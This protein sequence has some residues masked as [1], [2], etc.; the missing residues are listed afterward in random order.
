MGFLLAAAGDLQKKMN[1]GPSDIYWP[2]FLLEIHA[3]DGGL[4]A[5]VHDHDPERTSIREALEQKGFQV[6]VGATADSGFQYLRNHPPSGAILGHTSTLDALSLCR[7]IRAEPGLRKLPVLLMTSGGEPG[8]LRALEAGADEVV[9]RPVKTRELLARL[10]TL[11]RRSGPRLLRED[12]HQAGDLLVDEGRA[13]ATFR[14]KTSDMS[15]MEMKILR[16]LA[17]HPDRVIQRE[18][19]LKVLGKAIVGEGRCIDAHMVYIRRKLGEDLVET[20]P[21]RGYRLKNQGRSVVPES[22]E[23]ASATTLGG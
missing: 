17:A 22:P 9:A 20:V 7:R 12:I 16:V 15:I 23:V 13:K 18:E 4:I 6:V 14:G 21:R 5:V 1:S 19:F 3:M 2:K 10:R 8:R 11:L